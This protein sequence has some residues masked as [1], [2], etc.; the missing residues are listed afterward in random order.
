[1]GRTWADDGALRRGCHKYAFHYRVGPPSRQWSL[2]TFLK[3]PGGKR[4]ASDVILSGADPR[5]GTK[6]F[7]LCRSNTRA[8]RFTIRSKLTYEDS[9]TGDS[10]SGWLRPSHFRLHR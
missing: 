2:E 8:G 7:D 9:S 4:L 10:R 6:R 5:R 1:M 3:G